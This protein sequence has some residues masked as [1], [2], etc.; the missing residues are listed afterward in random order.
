MGEA[1]KRPTVAPNPELE[2]C[3]PGLSSDAQVRF[4]RFSVAWCSGLLHLIIRPGPELPSDQ[5]Q[6]E[7]VHRTSSSLGFIRWSLRSRD[8]YRINPQ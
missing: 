3:D 1:F 6:L 8:F 7:D 2:D 4:R 5:P